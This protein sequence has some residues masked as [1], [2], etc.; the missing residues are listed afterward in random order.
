MRSTTTFGNT[1]VSRS[2]FPFESE[3]EQVQVRVQGCGCGG[4]GGCGVRGVRHTPG[5]GEVRAGFVVVDA[6]AWTMSDAMS[7]QLD[8]ADL[9]S[10]S[11]ADRAMFERIRA[12]RMTGPTFERYWLLARG[13]DWLNA[14]Y[15]ALDRDARAR[16]A[17]L[18]D[19]EAILRSARFDP[20]HSRE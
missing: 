2:R 10:L 3:R 13:A 16:A 19:C 18:A 17:D 7:S 12:R 8:Q 11:D 9:D 4:A 14:T 1:V 20:V 15:R 6:R 5:M